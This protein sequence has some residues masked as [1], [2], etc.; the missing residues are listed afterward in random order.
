M[1]E[2]KEKIA[3]LK[4]ELIAV[5]HEMAEKG[6]V[7]GSVG[8]I[9]AMVDEETF[10]ISS[11]SS[12]LGR[13]SRQEFVEVNLKGEKVEESSLEPSSE[14]F[15]HMELYKK[16]DDIRSIVHTH[17]PYASAYAFLKRPLKTV[18]PESQFKLGEIAIISYMPSGTKEFAKAVANGLVAPK[19][20]ALLERHGVVATGKRARDAL[21]IAEM[22]EETARI[23]YLVDTL[24]LK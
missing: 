1:R 19:K 14:L 22:I 21:N 16:R 17:S 12:F 11:T 15:M 9:S 8:N 18:N 2:M 6:L 13:I 20:A 10:L 24:D 7:V 4:E 23:N 3:S 5:S